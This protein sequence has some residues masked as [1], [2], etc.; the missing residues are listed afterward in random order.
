MTTLLRR[1]S[2][3]TVL[4]KSLVKHRPDSVDYVATTGPFF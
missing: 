4:E 2:G 3:V 1:V